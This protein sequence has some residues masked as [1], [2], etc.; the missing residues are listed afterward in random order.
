ME[1]RDVETFGDD[2]EDENDN[3]D[4]GFVAAEEEKEDLISKG[5]HIT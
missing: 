2:D 1:S 3:D 4:D 5:F